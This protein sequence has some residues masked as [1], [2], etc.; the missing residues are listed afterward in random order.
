MSIT[1]GQLH[2]DQPTLDQAAQ[3]LPPERF[4]LG[5]ADAEADGLPAAGRV[6]R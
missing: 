6:D 3:E 5:L 2:P 1:D 4:G